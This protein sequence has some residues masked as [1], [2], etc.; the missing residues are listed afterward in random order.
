MSDTNSHIHQV[1]SSYWIKVL[2]WLVPVVFG[3]GG[4]YAS[5]SH[6]KAEVQSFKTDLEQVKK[7]ISDHTKAGVGHEATRSRLDRIETGQLRI[8]S[9]QQVQSENI[10]AICQATNARCK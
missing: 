4:I 2:V 5:V 6:S 10:A 1:L 3:A 9:R 8:M 7:E